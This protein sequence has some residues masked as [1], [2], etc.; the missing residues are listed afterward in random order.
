MSNENKPM[1]RLM[2]SFAKGDFDV[3][4]EEIF[5]PDDPAMETPTATGLFKPGDEVFLIDG[6]KAEFVAQLGDK[7]VVSP[8]FYRQDYNGDFDEDEAFTGEPKVVDR[9]F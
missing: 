6:R 7:W 5:A 8:F 2:Q 1:E 3:T 4:A 9:I